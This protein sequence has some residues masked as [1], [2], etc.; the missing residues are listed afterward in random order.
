MV[1][2]KQIMK[3]E[4]EFLEAAKVSDLEKGVMRSVELK[5]ID[6]LI[7]NVDGRFYG[8][9]DRCGHMNALLSMGT[10]NG[11]IVT[12]PFHYGQFDV[13]TGQKVKDPVSES[14]KDMDKLP[15]EMQKFLIYAK[16]LVDP[17]KTFDMQTHEVKVEG[18][19]ILVRI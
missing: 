11:K 10:L 7:A 17:V 1:R 6:I 18:N 19:K 13:T 4:G 14:F 16:K 15:E 2:V 12:C 9:D 5:G 8:L 3:D